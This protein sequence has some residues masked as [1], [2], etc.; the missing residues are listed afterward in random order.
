MAGK[1]R[2]H[3]PGVPMKQTWPRVAAVLLAVALLSPPAFAASGQS[4]QFAQPGIFT[5]FWHYLETL[6]STT[7]KARGSMDPN[8]SPTGEARGSMDSDG[9]PASASTA[10]ERDARGSM[11]PNGQP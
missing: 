10:D 2:S 9:Q 11:D 6:W 8:G 1:E 3:P 4:T 5:S 7:E